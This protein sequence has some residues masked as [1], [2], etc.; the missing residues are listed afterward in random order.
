MEFFNVSGLKIKLGK[1]SLCSKEN[2]MLRQKIHKLWYLGEKYANFKGSIPVHFIMCSYT[3]FL[4][5][6]GLNWS[7]INTLYGRIIQVQRKIPCNFKKF[8]NCGRSEKSRFILKGRL[9]S[10]INNVFQSEFFNV[11]GLK[12]NLE[13]RSLWQHYLGSKESS[14]LRPEIHKSWSTARSEMS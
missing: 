8:P 2:L 5:F 13:N 10:T 3:N 1:R 11:S 7:W 9:K 14:K 12:L 4:M 6:E